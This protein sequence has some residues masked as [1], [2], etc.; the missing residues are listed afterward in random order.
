[1]T[2]RIEAG[3]DVFELNVGLAK[4]FPKLDSAEMEYVVHVADSNHVLRVNSDDQRRLIALRICD[5]LWYADKPT[6]KGKRI[7]DKKNKDVEDAIVVYH[8]DI[9]NNKRKKIGDTIQVLEDYLDAQLEFIKS[10]KTADDTDE[11]VKIYNATAKSIK[12][13][14]IKS[15]YDQIKFFEKELSFEYEVPDNIIEETKEKETVE[16]NTADNVDVNKL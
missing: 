3:K 9:N 1:M 4:L 11:K 12:D 13:E 10:L 16:T 14:T 2:V 15:T 7:L 5:G 6:V 8:R